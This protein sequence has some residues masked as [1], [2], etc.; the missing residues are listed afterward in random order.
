MRLW[1]GWP[2]GVAL[3]VCRP[4]RNGVCRARWHQQR[5]FCHYL[6]CAREQRSWRAAYKRVAAREAPPLFPVL[7]SMLYQRS[8]YWQERAMLPPACNAHREYANHH[9]QAGQLLRL[10]LPDCPL[11]LCID[12]FKKAWAL[13]SYSVARHT[14]ADGIVL[15]GAP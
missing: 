7:L 11:L 6:A 8:R 12:R 2:Y 15:Q 5:L 10:A 3:C 14:S 1:Y 9:R 13:L 4:H